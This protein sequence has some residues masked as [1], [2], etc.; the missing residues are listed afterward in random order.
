MTDRKDLF[1]IMDSRDTVTHGE[2]N[3]VAGAAHSEVSPPERA[4]FWNFLDMQLT[5]RLCQQ[6]LRAI[7]SISLRSSLSVS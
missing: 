5:S 1:G 4:A 3:K 6:A 7:A 2:G